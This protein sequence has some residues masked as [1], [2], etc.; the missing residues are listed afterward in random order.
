MIGRAPVAE[1]LLPPGAARVRRCHRCKRSVRHELVAVY[2]GGRVVAWLG[3]RCWDRRKAETRT[4]AVCEP[5]ELPYD[6]DGAQ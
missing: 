1:A 4:G 6:Q 5:V 3:P 2:A